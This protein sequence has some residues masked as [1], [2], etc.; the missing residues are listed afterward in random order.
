MNEEIKQQK[1]ILRQ[2]LIAK[3]KH[4]T[5][6]YREEASEK[7]LA[8]VVKSREYLL[9]GTIFIYVGQE[10]EVNTLL[11]IEDAL[12]KGKRV[13]VPKIIGNGLMEAYE[14]EA[15]EDLVPNRFGIL[16]PK[17]CLYRVEPN[18]IDV[19]YVPCVA[20]TKEGDRLGHGGGYYDRFL[21]RGKFN[22][23]LVA[24]GKMEEETLP[25]EEFDEKVHQIITE[26]GIERI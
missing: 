10:D 25:N 3:R 7:I 26:N 8:H 1:K 11:I 9:A 6:A 19:T 24:F 22:R 23:T 4:L 2:S 17:E 15:T 14:L 20:F 13:A 21:L 12:A 5:K 16:E 18:D